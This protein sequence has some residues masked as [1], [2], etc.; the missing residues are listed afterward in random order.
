MNLISPCFYRG[1][2]PCPGNRL[3][4]PHKQIRTPIM[5][6]SPLGILPH[7]RITTYVASDARIFRRET[8][9]SLALPADRYRLLVCRPEPYLP[10]LWNL[11]SYGLWRHTEMSSV[12]STAGLCEKHEKRR[13]SMR[14][15][16]AHIGEDL[17]R[18]RSS[19]RDRWE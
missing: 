12:V 7:M 6:F 5:S 19:R 3:Q 9:H 15:R 11:G 14:S 10:W 8:V 16:R 17:I 13:Q 4:V 1:L 2:F 18:K